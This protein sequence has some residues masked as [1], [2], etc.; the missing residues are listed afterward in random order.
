M[1]KDEI[2]SWALAN[3]WQMIDGAPCLTKPK[4]PYPAIVRLVLKAFQKQHAPHRQHLSL[5]G[6][7]AGGAEHRAQRGFQPARPGAA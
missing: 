1:T 3:G 4:A 5:R 6:A 2:T 7:A